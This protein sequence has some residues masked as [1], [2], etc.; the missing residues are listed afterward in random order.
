MDKIELRVIN[1]DPDTPHPALA[2]RRMLA[3]QDKLNGK[4][5]L[6]R[7]TFLTNDPDSFT[8]IVAEPVR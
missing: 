4:L 8:V 5:L 2:G 1:A 7:G 6:T 3:I